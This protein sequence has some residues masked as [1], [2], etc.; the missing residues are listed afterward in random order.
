MRETLGTKETERRVAGHAWRF[1]L[2]PL[3]SLMLGGA[4]IALG[5]QALAQTAPTP[6]SVTTPPSETVPAEPEGEAVDPFAVPETAAPPASIA[7]TNE[8]ETKVVTPPPPQDSAS[9]ILAGKLIFELRPRYEF[10]DQIGF[11]REAKSATLRTR[12]GWETGAFHGFRALLEFENISQLNGE[13]YNTTINGKTT[14]PVVADPTVSEINRAQISW[15]N[16][17]NLTIVAGRQRIN[18]DDQRFIGG[19]AWRQ[20]EQTLDGV[21]VDFGLGKLRGSYT[22][23]NR[24]NRIFGEALDWEGDSHLLNF[25]YAISEPLK[26]QAFAYNLD[27]GGTGKSLA[28]LTAARNAST[29]TLGA[30]VSGKIWVG[31]IGVSYGYTYAEQ[32]DAGANPLNVD[33]GFSSAELI[34]NFDIYTVRLG[35]EVAE[36]NGVR[37]F[38]A[39]LGTAHAFQGWADAFDINNPTSVPNGVEDLNLTLNLRPRWRKDKFFN[40]DFTF[41]VHDFQTQRTG[42]DIGT[43]FDAQFTAS[44]TP[45]LSMIVKGAKFDGTD[46]PGSFAD[47]TKVWVGLEYRL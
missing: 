39:P 3:C 11:A 38:V 29:D 20:D 23:V 6:G 46:L 37:N 28:N 43:E 17:P 44:F 9:T 7:V 45:Q 26:L 24:V 5:G 12:L 27:F 34:G 30:R 15:S 31:L 4:V 33:L 32:K 8:P 10:V 25:N 36:G 19:V 47:R 2:G 16:G 42:V 1:K 22:F 13:N 41:R 14:F 40:L 21:K 35:Y 18:L